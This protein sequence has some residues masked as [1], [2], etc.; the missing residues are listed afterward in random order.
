[1]AGISKSFLSEI[2]HGT[3]EPSMGTLRKL[4]LELKTDLDS[5]VPVKPSL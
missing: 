1:M 4:A 5:L 2:E 3:K